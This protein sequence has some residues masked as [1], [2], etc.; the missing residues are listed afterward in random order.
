[1]AP[2]ILPFPAR[3]PAKSRLVRGID[4]IPEHF[5]FLSAYTALAGLHRSAT[6]LER[7]ADEAAATGRKHDAA[8]LRRSATA[9]RNAADSISGGFNVSRLEKLSAR[10]PEVVEHFSR[11]AA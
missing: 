2:K 6:T 5:E 7:L 4:P 9:A 10:H 8:A 11:G 1:M 3:K